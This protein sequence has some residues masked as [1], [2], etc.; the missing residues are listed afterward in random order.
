MKIGD[1]IALRPGAQKLNYRGNYLPVSDMVYIAAGVGIVP[2]LEQIRVVLPNGSSS[3]RSVTVIWINEDTSDFDQT[4]EQLE[5]EYFKYSTK[6][7][8]SCVVD[9]LKMNSLG[10]NKEVENALPAFT[11]GTMAVLSGPT[12]VSKKAMSYLMQKRGF[13]EDCICVL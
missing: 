4:S 12:E 2:I 5:R 10:D 8:V 6:L 1:E 3:V 9:T 7:A 11:P 13:P